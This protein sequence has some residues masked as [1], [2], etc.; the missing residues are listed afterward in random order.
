MPVQRATGPGSGKTHL[1][2]VLLQLQREVGR[3]VALVAPTGLGT[4]TLQRCPCATLQACSALELRALEVNS[5]THSP[6][7]ACQWCA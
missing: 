7:M 5:I 3:T 4:S 1:L 2:R 6:F